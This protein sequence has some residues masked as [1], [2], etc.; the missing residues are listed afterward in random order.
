MKRVDLVVSENACITG[1]LIESN[2][3]K[4]GDRVVVMAAEDAEY[5]AVRR[6]TNVEWALAFVE[7]F[8]PASGLKAPVIPVAASAALKSFGA[9]EREAGRVEAAEAIA[10]W[11]ESD[12]ATGLMRNGFEAGKLTAR[13]LLTEAIMTSKWRAR[14]PKP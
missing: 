5:A 9:R 4:P 12:D 3:F 7:V 1:A 2:G 14:L 11:L 10:A 6:Q 13:Q 8:G